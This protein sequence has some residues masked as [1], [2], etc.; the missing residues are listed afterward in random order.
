MIDPASARN[1]LREYYDT[2]TDAEVVEDLQRFSP[3]LAKRLGVRAA[4]ARE[5]ERTREGRMRGF[6]AAFGRSVQ[7]L[8]S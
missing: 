1:A 3:R 6:F 5:P 2:A 8:F 4:P 7:R